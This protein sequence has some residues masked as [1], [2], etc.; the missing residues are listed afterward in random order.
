GPDPSHGPTATAAGQ[1]GLPTLTVPDAGTQNWVEETDIRPT[2]LSLAGLRDDYLSDGTVLGVV[3]SHRG[4]DGDEQGDQDLGGHI[5]LD[6][7][8]DS[9]KQLNSSIGAFGTFALIADSA[10]LASSSDGDQTFSQIQAQ[11]TALADRRDAL[12]QSIKE[13]L[14]QAQH[15]HHHV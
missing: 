10:A 12:A 6:H 15:G 2:L 13:T 8:A 3:T 7:L 9:Y 11:L 5:L 1:N 14:D 4:E